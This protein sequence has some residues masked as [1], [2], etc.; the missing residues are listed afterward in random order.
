MYDTGSGLM[1]R[2]VTGPPNYQVFADT[3]VSTAINP[4]KAGIIPI[5]L[6]PICSRVSLPVG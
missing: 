5:Y 1:F 6:P 4:V 3:G 2:P